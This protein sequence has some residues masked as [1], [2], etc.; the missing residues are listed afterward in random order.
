MLLRRAAQS[1]SFA[2]LI[3]FSVGCNSTL[4]ES[5]D[6]AQ[7]GEE[8]AASETNG[9]DDVGASESPA[10]S[11]DA[12]AI[13]IDVRSADEWDTGHVASAVNIPHSEI[14]DRIAEV[15]DDKG[16]NIVLYCK[17]GGRAGRA[18]DALEGLGFTNVENAGGYDDVK[19]RFPAE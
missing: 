12:N 6:V 18:K 13:V 10:G 16:A 9:Q 5:A 8:A 15:T 14:A 17:S 2:L 3:S 1:L 4:E 19:D 11:D 7:V